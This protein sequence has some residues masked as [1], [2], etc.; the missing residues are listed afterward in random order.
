[1]SVIQLMDY[2]EGQAIQALVLY[3]SL[4]LCHFNVR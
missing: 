2:F 4:I 3:A 1:L